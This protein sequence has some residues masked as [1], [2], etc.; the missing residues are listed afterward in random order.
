MKASIFE[1][2]SIPNDVKNGLLFLYLGWLWFYI[3]SYFFYLNGEI[4]WKFIAGGAVICVLVSQFKNYARVLCLLFNIMM[5]LWCVLL[6]ALFFKQFTDKF[7]ASVV[8]FILFSLSTFYL[9]KKDA[10]DFFKAQ[11]QPAPKGQPSSSG[12]KEGG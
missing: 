7:I 3:A 6:S 12:D 1:F 9:F 5:I 10:A 2:K 4:P 11:S 8:N